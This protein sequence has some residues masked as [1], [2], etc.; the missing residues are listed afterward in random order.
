MELSDFVILEGEPD[1]LI[2]KDRITTRDP[3]GNWMGNAYLGNL[4]WRDAHKRLDQ[5]GARMITVNQHY[6]FLSALREGK[7]YDGHGNRLPTSETS[8]LANRIM[9]MGEIFKG[10]WIDAFFVMEGSATKLYQDHRIKSGVLSGKST[11][12]TSSFPDMEM[13]RNI[14][15]ENDS[16]MFFGNPDFQSIY[17]CNAKFDFK[18]TYLGVREVFVKE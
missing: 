9:H 6:Q 2:A 12:L 4:T 11:T 1:L 15:P 8:S 7:S 14:P 17:A 3:Q 5:R 16:T 13:A 10:E 18:D